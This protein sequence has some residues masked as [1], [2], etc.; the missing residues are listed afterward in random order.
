MAIIITY[1]NEYG[2][3]V[4]FSKNSGLQISSISDLS[5]N[6]ITISSATSAGQVGTTITGQKIEPK[7]MTIEGAYR[8]DPLVRRKLIDTILPGVKARFHYVDQDAG[9]DAYLEGCPTMTPKLSDNP[10]WQNFQFDFY[11]PYPY[12][13]DRSGGLLEFVSYESAFK[14]PRS[15]SSA[16]Q[17]KITKK[18]INQLSYISNTGS[19]PVGFV[20][21]FKAK[22][23]VSGPELLKVLT[24][25]VIRFS[26]LEMQVGDTLIVSTID[27]DRYCRLIRSGIETNVFFDMDFDSSFFKLD[28]GENPLRFDAADGY[29]NLDVSIEYYVTYAGV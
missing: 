23:D 17:W 6:T 26:D 2:Q 11:C 27:N 28:V 16:V 7:T 12:W 24:Q 20:A 1:E 19:V 3:S 5:S 29:E 21:R 18:T 8:Y 9:I 22:D 15:F 4:E 14:F 25:E 13:K 10:F